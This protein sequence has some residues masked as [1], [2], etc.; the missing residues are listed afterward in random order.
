MRPQGDQIVETQPLKRRHCTSCPAFRPESGCDQLRYRPKSVEPEDWIEGDPKSPIWIIGLNPKTSTNPDVEM[1]LSSDQLRNEFMK[2][3]N[4][5]SYFRDFSRVSLKLFS[6]LG[7]EK[8][9]AHTDIVKCD[10]A[11]WPPEGVSSEDVMLIEKS[12]A[13]YL[14]SQI[15][16][17]KP[18]LLICNGSSVSAYIKA[19]LTPQDKSIEEAETFF[20]SDKYGYPI[21]VILSGFIGR[22]DNY[23]KRRLGKEIEQHI[24]TLKI[25][26]SA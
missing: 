1:N 15:R 18:T 19:L 11:K 20:K 12:C 3:A 16:A 14:E 23:S 7:R 8:G 2:R 6:A 4:D 17:H 21:H 9:V 13:N 25:M 26:L 24:D 10:S 22:I 5:V